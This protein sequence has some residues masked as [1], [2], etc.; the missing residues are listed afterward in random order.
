MPVTFPSHAAA[1]LPLKLWR[2]R[3]FDGVALGVGS[4]APDLAYPFHVALDLRGHS[5]GS[6]LWWSLPLTLVA[7]SLL[8]WAAPVVAVHLP[9]DRW[10]ALRDYGALRRWPAW[11]V[12]GSS[13]LIGAASHLVWDSFTHGRSLRFMP[14]WWGSGVFG[15]PIWHLAQY[16]STLGGAAVA[17]W[18]FLVI[19]RRRLIRAWHGPAPAAPRTPTLFW[20]V[21]AAP[22][23]VSA[24]S[25]P[26]R[27]GGW[28]V[29]MQAAQG[30]YAIGLG[31]VL[32]ALT[33]SFGPGSGAAEPAAAGQDGGHG[34][35]H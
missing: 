34:V 32:A 9:A 20:P 12:T 22:L 28:A 16:V 26:W 8:R 3:W 14:G 24:V 13:A 2:P 35:P 31:L 5:W 21:A 10:F 18:L 33:V 4:M 7:A 23:V 19:G 27:L 1:A 30:L 17:V 11:W 15:V 25:W 29:H 6:L